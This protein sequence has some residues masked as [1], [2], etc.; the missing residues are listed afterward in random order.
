MWMIRMMMTTLMMVG[1]SLLNDLSLKP[2]SD[3]A[4]MSRETNESDGHLVLRHLR[5]MLAWSTALDSLTSHKHLS[6]ITGKLDIG[7]VHV[8]YPGDNMTGIDVITADFFKRFPLRSAERFRDQDTTNLE[9]GWKPKF[10]GT[11]H[12]EA[13]LMG[14]LRYFSEPNPSNRVDYWN[15]LQDSTVAD[16]MEAL[17]GPVGPILFILFLLTGVVMVR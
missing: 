16:R 8:P 17:I 6:I 2:P 10:T 7:L 5:A 14:L 11:T 1:C 4:D 12:A 13:T 15:V 9:T 3:L